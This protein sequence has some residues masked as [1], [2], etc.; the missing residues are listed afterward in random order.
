M[1]FPSAPLPRPLDRAEAFFWLLDRHSSMNFCVLAEGGGALSASAVAAALPGLQARHP[2]L[3]VAVTLDARQRLTFTPAPLAGARFFESTA[4]PET[5]R[6]VLAEALVQPFALDEAPLFRA[7]LIHLP[8]QRWVLALSFHHSIGDARSGFAVLGELLQLA[9]GSK[10]E[11][12]PIAPRPPLCDLYPE[13]WRGEAGRQ[14]AEAL[15]AIK[16]DEHKALGLPAALPGY[17]EH[18]RVEAPDFVSLYYPS[19]WL[20]QVGRHAR[21]AGASLHGVIGAALLLAVS[22]QLSGDDSPLLSLTSPADLRPTLQPAMDTST[23]GFYVTLLTATFRVGNDFWE[24]A[25]EVTLRNREHYAR[26]DGHL[27]YHFFPPAEHFPL[28]ATGQ[29][30]FDDMMR[31]GPQTTALSNVGRLPALP[32]LAGL[33]LEHLSFA[34]CPAPKQPVFASASTYEGRLALNLAYDRKRLPP[35][36]LGTIVAALDAHLQRAA[37]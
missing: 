19:A 10:H 24:L 15:K 34:L 18:P 23:P 28:D 11:S 2:L 21:A 3:A 33:H 4:T 8:A 7:H 13:Q 32:D 37:G 29:A 14:A 20:E 35:A 6:T 9:C 27:L 22:E 5:W 16:R 25:R 1:T 12:P 36:L 26:G 31:R 30:A 17:T